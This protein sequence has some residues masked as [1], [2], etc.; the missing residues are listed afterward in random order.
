[1]SYFLDD[2]AYDA[3]V[4]SFMTL[5]NESDFYTKTELPIRLAF[6][7]MSSNLCTIVGGFLAFG[8][9]HMRG[10]D[11]MAGWRWLFLFECVI[12]Y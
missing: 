2:L 3:L 6:F 10:I 11:D 4:S 5:T 7:W 1:M 9:L 8:I 12:L